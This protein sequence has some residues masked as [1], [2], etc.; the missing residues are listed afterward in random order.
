MGDKIGID[1]DTVG[2]GPMSNKFSTLL[3][4]GKEEA[5]IIQANVNHTYDRF[6]SVISTG[7]NL[8]I[9]EQQEMLRKKKWL[10]QHL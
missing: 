5:E 4:W 10:E 1:A 9:E 8:K 7:R 2:T 3:P 6:V